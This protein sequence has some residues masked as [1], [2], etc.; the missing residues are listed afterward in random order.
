[1]IDL[2]RINHSIT[3]QTQIKN[4]NRWRCSFPTSCCP[5]RRRSTATCSQA[6]A[7]K[8]RTCSQRRRCRGLSNL[9]THCVSCVVCRVRGCVL[10]HSFVVR[11]GRHFI[12][13]VLRRRS[14]S[15][16]FERRRHRALRPHLSLPV[17]PSR[18]R[19]TR[20]T[21][22]AHTHTAH[23][24]HTIALRAET[25]SL[26]AGHH[27]CRSSTSSAASL[28]TSRIWSKNS[29]NPSHSSTNTH[30]TLRFAPA[31]RVVCR[32]THE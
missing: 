12:W 19:R 15:A 32:G 10:W 24:A 14:G 26:N 3:K 30:K 28:W 23:T 8:V 20:R 25:R 4:I 22:T 21:H 11:V 1:L 31:C 13:R 27:I 9:L 16:A 17:R 18:T 2:N 7:P 6:W 5:T 29:N